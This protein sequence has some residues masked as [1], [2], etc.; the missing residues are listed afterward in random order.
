MS[1]SFEV[2]QNMLELSI[3]NNLT[4][5][6]LGIY[7]AMLEMGFDTVQYISGKLKSYQN[8]FRPSPEK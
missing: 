1:K 4:M 8:L 7:D 2:I 3:G 6:M 5:Q